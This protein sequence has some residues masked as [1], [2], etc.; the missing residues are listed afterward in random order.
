MSAGLREGSVAAPEFCRNERCCSGS[1]WA[2]CLCDGLGWMGEEESASGV[3][4]A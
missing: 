1:E 2:K 3:C 4:K